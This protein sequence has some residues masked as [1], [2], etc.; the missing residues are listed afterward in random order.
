MEFS[1]SRIGGF[2]SSIV[3]VK[4]GVV[5]RELVCCLQYFSYKQL[6]T[7]VNNQRNSNVYMARQIEW[8][9]H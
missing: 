3:T 2:L 6:V 4:S 1:S 7:V 9:F 5:C 8:N